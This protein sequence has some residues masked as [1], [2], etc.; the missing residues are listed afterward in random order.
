MN[1]DETVARLDALVGR[2]VWIGVRIQGKPLVATL[3]GPLVGWRDITASVRAKYDQL[4]EE[5]A[6]RQS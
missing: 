2:G 6:K 1:Y 4:S 5:E 3:M